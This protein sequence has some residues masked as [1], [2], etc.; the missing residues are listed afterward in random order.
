MALV[1][2]LGTGHV[3]WAEDAD[4]PA[5]LRGAVGLAVGG[6]TALAEEM[7]ELGLVDEAGYAR[8]LAERTTARNAA[9]RP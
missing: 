5:S 6:D 3:V 4:D 9:E 8:L 2:Q 7:V 1:S